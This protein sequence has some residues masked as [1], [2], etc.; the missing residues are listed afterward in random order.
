LKTENLNYF[1]VLKNTEEEKTPTPGWLYVNKS[2]N[3]TFYLTFSQTL[4]ISIL[5]SL[6][7]TE[8]KRQTSFHKLKNKIEINKQLC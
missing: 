1:R 8:C 3:H 5:T 2:K 4:A 7:S 6:T